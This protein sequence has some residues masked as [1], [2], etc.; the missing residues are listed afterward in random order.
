MKWLIL[1]A[2]MSSTPIEPPRKLPP[3]PMNPVVKFLAKDIWR[4]VSYTRPCFEVSDDKSFC[5]RGNYPHATVT[6]SWRF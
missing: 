3:L 2:M 5:V 6:F 4:V 1:A